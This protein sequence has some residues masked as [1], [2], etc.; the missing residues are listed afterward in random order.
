MDRTHPWCRMTV[1]DPAGAPDVVGWV[2]DGCGE[3]DLSAI[4]EV[5]RRALAAVRAGTRLRIEQASPA[6]RALLRLAALP[7][8]VSGEPE[9]GEQTVVAGNQEKGHLG[10]LPA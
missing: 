7:V 9:G 5:A 10:D 6:M 3:P 2:V 4:D 1:L 8:E